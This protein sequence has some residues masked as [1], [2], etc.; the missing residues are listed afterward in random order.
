MTFSWSIGFW[1]IALGWGLKSIVWRWCLLTSFCSRLADVYCLIFLLQATPIRLL[2]TWAERD[3][4]QFTDEFKKSITLSFCPSR[5]I[6][7]SRL[8]EPVT[9][10]D[11]LLHMFPPMGHNPPPTSIV[12]VINVQL[13][14][15]LTTPN[16]LIKLAWGATCVCDNY[17][18]VLDCGNW[19][20]KE[21][22]LLLITTLKCIYQAG[23]YYWLAGS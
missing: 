7:Q 16:D 8:N 20:E 3:M 4:T 23:I 21:Y 9:Y 13:S 14:Q 18:Y 17:C 1:I 22:Y 11:D 10:I 12:N 5:Y 15:P 19:L 2:R 6:T